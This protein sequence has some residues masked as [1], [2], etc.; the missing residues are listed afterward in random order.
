M[1]SQNPSNFYSELLDDRLKIV[2][3]KLLD[4]R[5]STFREMNSDFDDNYTR[6]TP[7]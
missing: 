2:A 6:E 5:H 4:I 1:N 7:I 3:V